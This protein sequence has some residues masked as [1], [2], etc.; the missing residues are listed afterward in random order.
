MAFGWRLHKLG[1]FIHDKGNIRPSHAEMLEANNHMTIR[2]GIDRRN[3]IVSSERSTNFKWCRD[4]FGVDHV[5]F[6]QMIINIL[7]LT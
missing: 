3:T 2:G 1:E 6:A 4:R 7:L 5:V